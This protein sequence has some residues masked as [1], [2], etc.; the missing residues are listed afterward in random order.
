MNLSGPPHPIIGDGKLPTPCPYFERAYKRRLEE[1]NRTLD[2]NMNCL[3]N[4]V[5]KVLECVVEKDQPLNK[6]LLII[7]GAVVL[8]NIIIVIVVT[9]ICCKCNKKTDKAV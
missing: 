1:L 8:G 4:K 9:C 7:I 5:D 2:E 6:E 3:S